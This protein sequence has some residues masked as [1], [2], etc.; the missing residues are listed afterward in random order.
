MGGYLGEATSMRIRLSDVTFGEEEIGDALEVLRST[1]VTMGEKCR[2]FEDAFATHLGSRNAVYVNSGSSANLLAWFA[3]ANAQFPKRP[4][5]R[6][7]FM[8]AE[9]IVPAVTWSTTIWPIVQA[10]GVPVL[11]DSDP[12]TLQ[13][14]PEAV[15]DAIG[16]DTVAICPVHALG[17]ACDMDALQAIAAEHKLWLIEDTCEAL[18]T[19]Y[20]GRYVGTFGTFG[21]FSFFFSHHITTI[22]GGMVIT[23]DDE[24]AELLRCLRAHG[25]TRDLK[26]AN[27]ARKEAMDLDSRFLFVNLGFN[28]RPTEVGGAF[29]LRQLQKLDA[30]NQRRDEITEILRAGLAPLVDSGHVMLMRPT[31]KTEAAFFGFPALCADKN[32]RDALAAH[33]DRRGIEIRPIICGNMARQPAFRHVRHRIGGS[34]A[35]A[36]RIMDCGLY[37]G[38]HPTLQQTDIDF[39]LEVVFEH[40]GR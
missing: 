29:G 22:E 17:N 27:G 4:N 26:N 18:G 37:W 2:A 6:P 24:L 15:R 39:I 14:R 23:D 13:L 34:L 11:V 19:R 38:V 40:F 25:W 21:T 7:W 10:G 36:D 12:D 32:Q 31:A 1:R 8:G 20:D 30:F 3:L 9:V 35:G 33:M 5:L 16:P 28:L